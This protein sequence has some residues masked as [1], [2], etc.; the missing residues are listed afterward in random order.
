V[1][2]VDT[3]KP[4]DWIRE[5]NSTRNVLLGIGA[6]ALGSYVLLAVTSRALSPHEYSLF[7]AY[8]SVVMGLILGATNPLETFGLGST[9]VNKNELTI[10]R[11]FVSAVRLVTVVAL[12]VILVLLPWTVTRVFDG[13]W[14]F[15]VATILALV[16]FVLTYSARG[17][18][19]VGHKS[20][21]YAQL[22][23]AE[24]CLRVVLAVILI[25]TVGAIGSSVALA[26]SLAA[27]LVGCA[28]FHSVRSHSSH[29]LDFKSLDFFSNTGT[30]LPL[31]VASLATF[32]LLNLGPFVVQ[33]LAGAQASAAGVYLNALTLS[34]VP[35][36]L[37]PVLQAR[38]VPSVAA[39][40]SRE[41]FLTLGKLIGKGLRGLIIGGAIFV[42]GFAMF[43]D[44]VID[45]LFGGNTTLD[46]LDLALLAIPT[47]LYLLAIAFQ[48]VLVAL[49]ET[50]KIAKA[51]VIGLL[52]YLLALLLPSEAILKVEVAGV[53][54]MSTVV[55]LLFFQL[56]RAMKSGLASN[57]I[58]S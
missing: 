54:A 52:A 11:E 29:K 44:T 2:S 21:R 27:L 34:R 49:K 50:K 19:I 51:W 10:D 9:H 35:I 13:N 26:V 7:A 17:V 6:L 4:S 24:S 33:F 1:E 16:G 43:G 22:M 30:F 18:L 38:L 15:L 28:S 53:V 41:E 57:T 40:L 12:I 3:S 23:T 45:F 55:I 5:P 14:T 20:S 8:W 46:H 48:S 42:T 36:M 56:S 32:V 25:T 58:N 31:L 37:G 47:F 39:I